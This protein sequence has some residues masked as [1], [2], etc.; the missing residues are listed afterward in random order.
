MGDDLWLLDTGATGHFTHDPRLLES[1]AECSRVLRCAGGSTLPIVGTGT[2]RLSL[3]SGEGVAC[4]TLMNVAHVPGLSH[5]L[6][7]LR[8]I[9]DAGNKYL[10]TREGIRLVLA[11]SSDELFAPSCGQ[12]NGLFGYRSD[13][14]SEENLHAVI[15]PGARPTSL[16]ADINELHCPHGHMHEDLLRKT[17]KQIG[18][19]L[20]GQLVPSQG[21]SEAKGIKKSVK[22]FTYTRATKPAARCFGLSGPKSVS[23]MGGT[24]YMMIVRDD[25]S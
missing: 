18:V 15:T 16:A 14:S 7:S 3:R 12:L 1:Y 5:H 19:K 4:V 2:L 9:A 21:C 8:R 17:A 25:Y 6:L 13:R 24:K 20:Q 23:S 22:S 11:K 10:G